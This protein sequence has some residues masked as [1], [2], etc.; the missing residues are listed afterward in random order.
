M[1]VALVILGIVV[2][3]LAG[4]AA[5]FLLVPGATDFLRETTVITDEA[6]I[7]EMA[8][9]FVASPYLD[10]YNTTRLSGYVD[11]YSERDIAVARCEMQLF[12][13]TAEREELVEFTVEDIAPQSRKT[14][15]VNAG[16]IGDSRTAEIT[17][18]E[19]EVYE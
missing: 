12:N 10:D 1:R 7:G 14:F 3:V 18:I 16:T 4:L 17:I 19:L 15:E 2:L 8:V 5:Y 6:A 9:G 11:N 13:E